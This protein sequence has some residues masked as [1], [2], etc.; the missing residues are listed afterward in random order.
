MPSNY[1]HDTNYRCIYLSIYDNIYVFL[2]QEETLC[3]DLSENI[4]FYL[5]TKLTYFAVYLSLK[6]VTMCTLYK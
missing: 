5:S 1:I 4:W 3:Y 6:Y 2:V